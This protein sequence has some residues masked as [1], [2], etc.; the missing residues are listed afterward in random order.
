MA[1]TQKKHWNKIKKVADESSFRL[2]VDTV[3][4]F[5]LSLMMK[6]IG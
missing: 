4:K 5:S 3:M 2:T 1:E 6:L